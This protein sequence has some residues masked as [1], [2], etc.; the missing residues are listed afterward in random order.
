VIANIVKVGRL[1]YNHR[2]GEFTSGGVTISIGRYLLFCN[3]SMTLMD[4]FRN[5]GRL[6]FQAILFWVIAPAI[7]LSLF[8]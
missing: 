2:S 1:F 6:I 4:S 8:L 7:A 5:R 3:R